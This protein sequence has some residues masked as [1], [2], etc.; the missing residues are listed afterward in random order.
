MVKENQTVIMAEPGKQQVLITREFDAPR[1]LVFQAWTD[2]QLYVKWLSPKELSMRLEKFEPQ[3]G[4]S[5]KYVL[6]DKT[7]NEFV[8]HGVF[9]EITFP[10]RIVRTFEFEGQK[11]H[12]FLDSAK[13]EDLADDKTRVTIR[14]VFQ[15]VEDRDGKIGSGMERGVH[16]SHERLDE[17]LATEL[18]KG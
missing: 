7:G 5:W 1:E 3:T 4:G 10:E 15:T 12:A 8:F 14:Y 2:P 11:G 18:T 9:H 16:D 13:F 17:L 6:K